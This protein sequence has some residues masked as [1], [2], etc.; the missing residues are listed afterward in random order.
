[1]NL[2]WEVY[3]LLDAKTWNQPLSFDLA[4]TQFGKVNN[5]TGNRSNAGSAEGSL[6]TSRH[7]CTSLEQRT[8]QRDI[9]N[10]QTGIPRRFERR[11]AWH[12]SL[13]RH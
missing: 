13:S 2:R 9:G 10:L 4:N 7:L 8:L 3:D 12:R 5:A 11:R 1:M 6:L